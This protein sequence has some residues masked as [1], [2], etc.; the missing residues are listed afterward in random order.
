MLEKTCSEP[1]AEQTVNLPD[2]PSVDNEHDEHP[3]AYPRG[4]KL[5]IILISLILSILLVAL[6][7]TIIA[8]AIPRITQEFHSLDQVGWYGSAY[9][10]TNAT[11]QS[12]WGKAYTYFDLKATLMIGIGL[13][14]VGTLVCALSPNSAVFIFGRAVAGFGGSGITSGAFTAVASIAP[15]RKRAMYIGIMGATYGVASVVGP[16]LGGVFTQYLTFRWCFWINLPV[17]GVASCMIAFFFKPPALSR[18]FTSPLEKLLQMDLLGALPLLGSLVCYL[19]AMRWAGASLAWTSAPV[20]G[21]L[22]TSIALACLFVVIEWQSTH[23]AMMQLRFFHNSEIVFNLVY[24]FFLS[25]L[26]MPAVYYLSIQFQSLANKSPAQAGIQ[27]IPLAL[28]VSLGTIVA[29][30]CI[31]KF[32]R[33]IIWLVSGPI[34]ATLGT[35]LVFAYSRTASAAEWV[36]FQMLI[37][38][39]VGFS[40]Q[41]PISI[42]QSLVESKDIATIIGITL[43]WESLGACMLTSAAEAAFDNG[44]ITSLYDQDSATNPVT[45]IEAGA[46][47][48]RATFGPKQLAAVLQAYQQGLETA[49]I[50]F[51][52]C[53]AITVFISLMIL[54][55]EFTRRRTSPVGCPRANSGMET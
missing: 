25:G 14:E 10:L 49:Y 42:N 18:A 11:F 17:G 48:L 43:F 31:S 32:G 37:G 24:M 12:V 2:Q 52:A 38:F 7:T 5:F 26:Y 15:A 40:L 6:D 21:T 4:F 27:L 47:D 36:G 16:V 34:L 51:L 44:L 46:N 8:T 29:N 30:T 33:A 50:L 39:G 35:A 13:F 45:V 9:F 54:W 53:G 3:E 28:C 20:I 41:T 55:R 22:A 19:L 23:R 1:I